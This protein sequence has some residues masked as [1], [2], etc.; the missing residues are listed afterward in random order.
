MMQ[1]LLDND[2]KT[3]SNLQTK[4]TEEESEKL[5]SLWHFENLSI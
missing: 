2:W 4:L 3:F 5:I 1:E